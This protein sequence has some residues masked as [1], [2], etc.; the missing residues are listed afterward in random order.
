MG[1]FNTAVVTAKG[2]ALLTKTLAGTCK[3]GFTRIALSDAQLT[4]DLSSLTE[5]TQIRQS[6]PVYQLSV[7]NDTTVSCEVAFTNEKLQTGYYVRAIG[8][9][10]K[11]PDEGEI[12]YSISTADESIASADWMPPFIGK[13]VISYIVDVVT[14]VANSSEVEVKVDPSAFVTVGEF[15]KR[16]SEFDR[17]LGDIET[18]LGGI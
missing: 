18:L 13:G 12:L 17:K 8:L 14:T 9:Y 16:L 6:E 10:A 11:D 7:K 1:M 15:E 5:L 4:G 2:Q 3:V